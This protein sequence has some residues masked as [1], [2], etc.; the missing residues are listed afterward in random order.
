MVD[1]DN[2]QS[3]YFLNMI[4][5][6]LAIIVAILSYL[7]VY[8]KYVYIPWGIVGLI[9]IVYAIYFDIKFDWKLM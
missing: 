8:F 1:L 4:K 7:T 5:Y 6:C 3:V 9:T 2:Y